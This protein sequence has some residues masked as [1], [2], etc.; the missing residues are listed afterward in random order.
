MK[1]ENFER[2][3]RSL[4]QAI[5]YERGEAQAGR[6]TVRGLAPEKPKK[7][8]VNIWLDEDIVE[9]FERCAAQSHTTSYQTQINQALR[10]FVDSAGHAPGLDSEMD[11]LAEQIAAKVAA[12]LHGKTKRKAAKAAA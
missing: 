4:E 3:Q 11:V 10:E 12:R 6:V 7:R 1:K 5:A 2:L 8:R 9:Y